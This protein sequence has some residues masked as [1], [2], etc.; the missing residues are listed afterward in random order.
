MRFFQKGHPETDPSG[1]WPVDTV[2]IY[3]E[4]DFIANGG[5][6]DSADALVMDD[7]V[8]RNTGHFSDKRIAV[9]FRPGT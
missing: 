9:M 7:L 2:K 8:K 4:E 5:T 3:S 1:L 6:L